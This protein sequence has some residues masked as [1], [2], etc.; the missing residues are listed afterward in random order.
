MRLLDYLKQKQWRF[1]LLI[2][3]LYFLRLVYC[4]YGYLKN[5]QWLDDS[6]ES[7]V[8]LLGLD[9]FITKHFP[10]WGA[11]IVY[12][13]SRIPGGL[14]G[15]LIGLPLFIWHHPFAPYLFLFIIQSISLIY[16]S[17]YLCR[18]FPQL[19][20]WIIYCIIVFAPFTLHTGLKI[21]NP[22]YVLVFSVPFMLSFI[23]SLKLFKLQFITP[24]WRY[25]WLSFSTA[26]VFQLHPSYVVMFIL[27]TIALLFTLLGNIKSVQ[28][29]LTLISIS[30]LG[31]AL[32][33]LPVVT[34][35]S[36]Y[37]F[38]TILTQGKNINFS[39]SHIAWAGAVIFYFITLCGYFMNEFCEV[40]HWEN[41]WHN[42]SVFSGIDF[43]ILQ[44]CGI[45]LFV[46]QLLIF[47]FKGVNSYMKE[48][49][50]FIITFLLILS[51]LIFI[52]MFSITDP[53][54]HAIIVFFPISVI[55]L[56]FCL[57]FFITK[58]LKPTYIAIFF[59]LAALYYFSIVQMDSNLPDLGYR[60]K[61]FK[62]IQ[63]HNPDE[64]ET[65]RYPNYGN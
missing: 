18:L 32:G 34:T 60:Q 28:L 44:V 21:I 43:I 35:I 52:Y 7:H 39:I 29:W 12:S 53:L 19:P 40:Y 30:I 65:L 63:D 1:L 45:A 8:Y 37:G 42:V 57:Q 27:W 38:G 4:Y 15:L 11:D 56:C 24:R 9:F 50:R 20:K 14:Q 13:H 49:K 55:Y 23:E 26:C 54:T 25:F 6:D 36:H 64:F 22:A 2:S 33:I 31:F 46:L 16:L 10:L 41:L 5:H 51:G 17:W 61:V 59:S 58:G 48:Y 3:L 62:A 47:V